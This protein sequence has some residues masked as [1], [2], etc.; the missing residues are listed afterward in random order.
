MIGEIRESEILSQAS[1]KKQPVI[2]AILRNQG[3]PGLLGR[4]WISKRSGV[5]DNPEPPVRDRDGTE[6]RPRNRRAPRSDQSR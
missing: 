3:N 1:V 2:L 5:I 4:S 6:Y